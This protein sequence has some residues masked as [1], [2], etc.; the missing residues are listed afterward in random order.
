M[1]KESSM[2]DYILKYRP[3][4]SRYHTLKWRISPDGLPH[5]LVTEALS[6]GILPRYLTINTQS[7]SVDLDINVEEPSN[8][9][10]YGLEIVA[11]FTWHPSE[12]IITEVQK[13]FDGDFMPAFKRLSEAYKINQL[14]KQTT[15][16]GA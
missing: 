2:Y 15:Q 8:S 14:I 12:E 7:G 3:G 13:K 16:E 11:F 10:D 4:Q 6:R 1:R 5:K 9:G